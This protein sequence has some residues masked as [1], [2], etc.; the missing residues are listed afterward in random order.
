MNDVNLDALHAEMQDLNAKIKELQ[1][2]AAKT[3]QEVFKSSLAKFFAAVPEVTEIFWRQYTP[4]FNDGDACEFS[5]GDVNFYVGDRENDEDDGYDAYNPFTKPSVYV[6]DHAAEYKAVG[7]KDDYYQPKIDA[8]NAFIAKYD[9]ERVEQIQRA[10]GD[11]RNM[12]REINDDYFLMMFGD[13]VEI[14]ATKD[15]FQVDEFDHD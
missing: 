15:G 3:S 10:I 13:H 9:P 4:Y 2:Q 8:Y 14:T 1:D 6:Y 5:V 7:K 12:F 11:V